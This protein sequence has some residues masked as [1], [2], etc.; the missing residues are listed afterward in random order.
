MRIIDSENTQK[1]MTDFLVKDYETLI[2]EYNIAW[3]RD[4]WIN[5]FGWSPET[6]KEFKKLKRKQ[7]KK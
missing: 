2:E 1:L 4:V 7:S 5:S 6:F 3:M